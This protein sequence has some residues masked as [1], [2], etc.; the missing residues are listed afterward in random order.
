[1]HNDEQ[2]TKQNFSFKLESVAVN[3]TQKNKQKKICQHHFLS[4]QLLNSFVSLTKAVFLF[5][6]HHTSVKPTRF[7]SLLL[8][9]LFTWNLLLQSH[10]T[11][12]KFNNNVSPQLMSMALSLSFLSKTVASSQTSQRAVALKAQLSAQ[13]ELKPSL[14]LSLLSLREEAQQLFSPQLSKEIAVSP[15]WE[16]MERTEVKIHSSLLLSS[17]MVRLFAAMFLMSTQQTVVPSKF[18]DDTVAFHR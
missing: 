3:K 5:S 11:N 10:L 1:M 16:R 7:H 8:P 14:F 9:S 6:Q 17:L 2:A 15:F 4:V 13:T 18:S 12:N